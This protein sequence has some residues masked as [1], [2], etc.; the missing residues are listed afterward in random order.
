MRTAKP[1][2]P[3]LRSL[4]AL[5]GLRRLALRRGRRRRTRQLGKL[6]SAHALHELLHFFAALEQAVD[7]LARCARA[8]RAPLPPRAVDPLRQRALLRRHREDDR[9]DA[10]ELRLVD[11]VE[12]LELLAEAGNELH[13][14]ADRAHALDHP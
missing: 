1:L 13:E 11:L 5:V 12:P 2:P 7:L 10:R 9:L 4:L 8:A 3:C 14:P 6:A